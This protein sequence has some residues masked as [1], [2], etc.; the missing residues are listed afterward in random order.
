MDTNGLIV[1]SNET[2]SM[3][4]GLP[5]GSAVGIVV[6][7][8]ADSPFTVTR[9]EFYVL[10]PNDT[11]QLA[12]TILKF[13]ISRNTNVF[14]GLF[15]E[16]M[17]EVDYQTND[18]NVTFTAVAGATN[19]YDLMVT[20]TPCVVAAPRVI[21]IRS[22]PLDFNMPYSQLQWLVGNGDTNALPTYTTDQTETNL[23]QL[24]VVPAVRLWTEPV[25]GI[26]SFAMM[27]LT[28]N[29]LNVIGVPGTVIQTATNANDI[30]QD[31]WEPD[32]CFGV[33]QFDVTQ[34]P[35]QFFIR[36]VD[37]SN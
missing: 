8:N 36:R 26:G 33:G 17:A 13:K 18:T 5:A 21:S 35:S 6:N 15:S 9:G 20:F 27:S 22:E 14:T 11:G 31:F 32:S 30:Y 25:T 3:L 7:G 19:L 23:V 37:T 29:L 12:N 28:P 34:N 24:S 2:P 1:D 10:L 4:D 16:P